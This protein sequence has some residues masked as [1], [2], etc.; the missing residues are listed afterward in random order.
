VK[1]R[2]KNNLGSL[3][4]AFE[5]AKGTGWVGVEWIH[6][7]RDG[8]QCRSGSVTISLPVTTQPQV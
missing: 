6:L 7:A 2:D 1:D 8:N 3:C 4:L 5:M